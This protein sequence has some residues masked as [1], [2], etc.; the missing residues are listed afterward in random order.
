MGRHLLTEM[1]PGVTAVFRRQNG[2][3]LME[4]LFRELVQ[5][6]STVFN[7]TGVMETK[8]QGPKAFAG[9]KV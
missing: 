5:L 9:T 7:W 6:A 3:G 2:H 8:H 4:V 1:V